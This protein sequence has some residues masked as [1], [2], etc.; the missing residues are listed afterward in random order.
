[1]AST[2]RSFHIPTMLIPLAIGVL[3]GTLALNA[4]RYHRERTRERPLRLWGRE[5]AGPHAAAQG[6]ADATELSLHERPTTLR[7][8]GSFFL[9]PVWLLWGDTFGSESLRPGTQLVRWWVE[10]K[11][12][13]GRQRR[14]D[15]DQQYATFSLSCE[16]THTLWTSAHRDGS[17]RRLEQEEGLRL[18]HPIGSERWR[19]GAP[20]IERI[21]A[22]GLDRLQL[23]D[24]RLSARVSLSDAGPPLEAYLGL[25]A[26]LDEL[27]TWVERVTP[28][29]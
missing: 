28:N 4:V 6:F 5:W 21:F 2:A 14:V 8:I 17:Q 20:L 25:F 26:A 11:G 7:W 13:N 29:S 23:A 15:L 9:S 16:T 18:L 1:M 3:L 24:G 10:G 27:A 22:L 12:A 19:S